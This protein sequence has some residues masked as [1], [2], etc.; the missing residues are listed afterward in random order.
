MI[1]SKTKLYLLLGGL[2]VL[3][4]NIIY[5]MYFDIIIIIGRRQAQAAG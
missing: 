4:S 3:L 1:F 5:F 2:N